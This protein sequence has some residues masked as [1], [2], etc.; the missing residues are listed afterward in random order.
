MSSSTPQLIVHH[1]QVGQGERIPFLL[2]E[3]GI[4]YE[5][6]LYQRAPIFSPPELR[7]LHPLGA[8]PVFEDR[9]TNPD[10]P[11]L[12]AESGAITEYIINKYGNGRLA[13]P[14]SHP[15]YA[16]YLYWFHFSNSSLQP[17]IMRLFYARG[18]AEPGNPRLKMTEERMELAVQHLND[19]LSKTLYLAGDEFTAA[20]VMTLWTFTTGRKF[21]SSDLSKYHGILAWMK[22]CTN[23]PA[24]RAALKK[25]DPDL[26]VEGLIS[27]EGPEIFGPLKA[28]TQKK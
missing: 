12:L 19:R 27:A 21:S 6:K 20:D 16:D 25:S 17:A 28:M 10:S 5:L 2:E 3:L 23:R 7:Q 22:R 8:S 4:P 9:T 18:M 1:L 15:N 13:L 26:N 14:P 11:L 24:Y